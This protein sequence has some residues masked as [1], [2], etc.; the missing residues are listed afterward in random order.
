MERV[1]LEAEDRTELGK[2]PVRAL[3]RAGYTPAVLYRAGRSRPIKLKKRELVK[4]INTTMGEQVM[5]TLKFPNEEKLALLK[6]YQVDP[7]KNELLHPDFY[8]VSLK[9]KVRVTVEIVLT[10]EPVGVKREGGI[11][12]HGLTEIEI[13]CLPEAIPP[14][15]EVDVTAL[16]AGESIHVGDL[17]L[18]EG[19]RVLEDPKEVL[20]TVTEPTAEAEETVEEVEE[21][22][23][24]VIKKGK[25]E[26]AA[27]EGE[28]SK[29]S[30]EE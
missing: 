22:E 18:P 7:V 23:P 14:H 8:E 20:A 10:G 25:K 26:E 5:I 24:E 6:D 9:E 19:I 21:A 12:Q 13:E 1:V 28:A 15:I 4:F 3:R 27:E 11:L 17:N 16:R 30:K 29:E 2:G